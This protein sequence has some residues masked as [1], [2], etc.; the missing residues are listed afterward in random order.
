[1]HEPTRQFDR[2]SAGLPYRA[3]DAEIMAIQAEAAQRYLRINATEGQADPTERLMLLR[4]ALGA[5]GESFLNPPVRWEYGRHIFIG[6]SCLINSNCTFLDGAEIRI[7][8]FTLIAPNCLLLTAGHPVLPEARIKTVPETGA[9]DHVIA[10][11]APIS[12][13]S[14]CWIGA[15]SI[16]LGGVTI[17]DGT[18]VGAGSVVTKSLPPRVLAVGNPARVIRKLPALL[19]TGDGAG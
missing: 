11:N 7:G 2:M 12:I 6:D 15:G 17:G 5:F 13:G 8:S 18:T 10:V 14:H 1:M 3:P 19:A 9:L 16:V 4:K